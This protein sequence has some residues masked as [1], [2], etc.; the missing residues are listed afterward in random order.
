MQSALRDEFRRIIP[1]YD[2]KPRIKWIFD[3]SAQ[4]TIVVSR[5]FFTQEVDNAFEELED[6]NED[7]LKDVLEMQ[8]VQLSDLIH[9]INGPLHKN[10]RKKLITLC[11]VDVHARDVVQL[12]INERVENSQGFQWQSQLRYYKDDITHECHISICDAAINYM[13][14]Y[15]GNVGCLCITPLTDRCYITLTQ[16]QQLGLGEVLMGER[17]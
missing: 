7:A 13:N 2:E 10:D 17:C 5:L 14:E 11:T 1:L 8:K 12:L 6:G 3:N 16:A 4:N 9:L 15:I